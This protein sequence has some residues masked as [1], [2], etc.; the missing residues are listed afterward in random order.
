M[1]FSVIKQRVVALSAAS[2][3][4]ASLAGLMTGAAA[5][6]EKRPVTTITG[7]TNVQRVLLREIVHALGG[8]QIE[9]VR[10]ESTGDGVRLE[11]RPT[12]LDRSRANVSVRV[13]WDAH[14]AA[15]SF[16]ARSRARGLP[17]VVSF[18][19]LGRRTLF[20]NAKDRAL[21][22]FEQGRIVRPVGRAVASSGARLIEFNLFRPRGP[23]LAVVVGTSTPARFIEKRLG[24]IITALNSVTRRIDGF[25]VA[26]TDARRSVVFAYGRVD[27]PPGVLSTTLYVHPDLIGCAESLPVENEVAPDGA[28]AC[29]SR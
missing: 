16:A 28:P 11:M 3:L 22:P 9:G 26:V 24:T 7:G 27:V 29:P 8:T 14:M 15:Y 2:A 13:G 10:I 19:V 21:P 17:S 18:N 25:Y 12:R 6:S 20:R 1:L 5:S 23:T 4:L